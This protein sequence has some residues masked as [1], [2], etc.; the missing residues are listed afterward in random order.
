MEK[1]LTWIEVMLIAICFAG[2]LAC[3]AMAFAH[4]TSHIE[5]DKIGDAATWASA[6]FAGGAFFGTLWI[7]N[8]S[9]RAT[10]NAKFAKATLTLAG[11]HARLFAV[12]AQFSILRSAI[13]GGL[14]E[15]S[16]SPWRGIAYRFMHNKGLW[17]IS[18]LEDLIVLDRNL[19]IDL[20]KAIGSVRYIEQHLGSIEDFLFA[21]DNKIFSDAFRNDVLLI[22]SVTG[23]AMTYLETHGKSERWYFF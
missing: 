18:E 3:I 7:A 23:R 12:N 21:I 4:F 11:M 6:L 1:K 13:N 15:D 22:W 9:S 10:E 14:L 5:K 2:A 19:A 8:S 16:N 17:Q 20:A